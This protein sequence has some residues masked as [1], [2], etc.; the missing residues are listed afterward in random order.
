MAVRHTIEQTN[1]AEEQ[2]RDL[3]M[4]IDYKTQD[5]PIQL[6]L[7]NLDNQQF[8]IPDYQRK[9]IW[10]P[11]NKSLFIESVLLGLPIP[12]MFF[13][14]CADG[15]LEIIDGA[16]RIQTLHEFR[17]NKLKLKGLQKLTRLNDF[18]FRDLPL[19]VQR[20]FENKPFRVVILDDKTTEEARQDLFNRINT[21]G[22][23]ANDSEVRRGSM[24]GRLTDFIDSCCTNPDFIELCPVNKSKADRQERF[25]LILRFFAYLYNYQAFVHDV[26]PFLDQFLRFN[27]DTF[28]EEMYKA[29][30]ENMLRFV[31]N[32]FEWGFAKSPNATVTPR[33]RFEALSVGSAL[34]LKEKPNLIVSNVDW[35]KS[36]EFLVHVTSDAS[37]NQGKLRGRIEYVR[38]R[39]L[40]AAIN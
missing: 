7:L 9:F 28:D 33:V 2:I 14:E 22:I 30:F 34:A 24:S 23:K 10:R 15:R 8:Y 17:N 35:I 18:Y 31:R 16:Q 6:L 3:A 27:L 20:K 11:K 38:D 26:G 29:D 39:L 1:L 4:Q 36:D 19:S 13:A 40:E 12:F 32:T 5:Y 37:N 21:S 25:E